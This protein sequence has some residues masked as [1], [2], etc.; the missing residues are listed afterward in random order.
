MSADRASPDVG[1]RSGDCPERQE[2]S[3]RRI[4][5]S[6]GGKSTAH[7]QSSQLVRYNTIRQDL[8]WVGLSLG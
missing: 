6:A 5:K 8:G 7:Q 1:D 3:Q 4:F 2:M